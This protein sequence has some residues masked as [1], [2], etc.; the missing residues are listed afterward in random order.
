M[1]LEHQRLHEIL[2]QY[3]SI[4]YFT[5]NTHDQSKEWHSDDYNIR[6]IPDHEIIAFRNIK[7][8][9]LEG[10]PFNITTHDKTN[11]SPILVF[12]KNEQYQVHV[13][14]TISNTMK[15]RLIHILITAKTSIASNEL[16]IILEKLSQKERLILT[17]IAK[18]QSMTQIAKQLIL[19]P[20]TVDS[21]RINLCEK[22]NVKRATELAV[23]ASRL[24]LLD[25][26]IP[27]SLVS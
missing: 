4:T 9:S 8:S 14:E 12:I 25:S 7:L 6:D 15:R 16:K 11:D 2:N 22:L 18:G 10:N 26:T 5:I 1:D 17:L 19:S 23:W 13:I 24:G 27:S 21:H 3:D 20:H